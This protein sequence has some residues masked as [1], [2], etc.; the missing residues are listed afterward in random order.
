MAIQPGA[1]K[2]GPDNATL[3]VKTGRSGAAAA[4]GHDLDIEVRSWE[5]TL[6]LGDTPSLHWFGLTQGWYWIE[7]GGPE[8]LPYVDY[9]V[10]RLWEDL[11]FRILAT[12]PEA[13]DH[14]THGLVGLHIMFR[15]LGS[16]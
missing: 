10:V 4:A 12:V 7:A 14:P 11:G 13:F 3:R 2:L 9:Y 5:A 1:H 8:P 16:S 15:K 6:D